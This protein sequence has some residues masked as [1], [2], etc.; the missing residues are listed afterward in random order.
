MV[1]VFVFCY[2]GYATSLLLVSIQYS[3]LSCGA[4]R[5]KK[6]KVPYVYIKPLLDQL[7]LLPSHSIDEPE[8]MCHVM[9]RIIS[10]S[11]LHLFLLQVCF[12]LST[13]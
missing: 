12:V 9:R 10:G 7:Y 13:Q 11:S 1:E 4:S 8:Y 6:I 3:L 5:R 2:E